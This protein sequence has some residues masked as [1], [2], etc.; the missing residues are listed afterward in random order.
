MSHSTRRDIRYVLYRIKDGTA[1][2]PMRE[3][4]CEVRD[5]VISQYIDK[6]PIEG[7]PH[8]WDLGI[9]DFRQFSRHCDAISLFY[10]DSDKVYRIPWTM[11]PCGDYS[12]LDV[13]LNHEAGKRLSPREQVEALSEHG[14]SSWIEACKSYALSRIEEIKAAIVSEEAQA[15]PESKD[16]IDRSVDSLMRAQRSYQVVVDAIEKEMTDGLDN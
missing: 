8:V 9:S 11:P 14:R 13:V 16:D 7:F 2:G 5:N 10:L 3:D 4:L 1:D 12:M 15:T 6:F